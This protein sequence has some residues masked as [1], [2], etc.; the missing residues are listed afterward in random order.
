MLPLILSVIYVF[1]HVVNS[2]NKSEIC[3]RSK[4]YPIVYNFRKF[5]NKKNKYSHNNKESTQRIFI[6]TKKI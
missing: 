6:V 2:T 4:T 3:I 1:L 5:R